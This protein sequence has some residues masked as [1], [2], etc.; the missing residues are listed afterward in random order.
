[1][2]ERI[3]EKLKNVRLRDILHILLFLL[4]VLP[5]A[6]YRRVRPHIWLVCEVNEARDNGY[7][8][9]RYLRLEQPR[10]DAVYAISRRSPDYPMVAD[11]GPTVEYGSF[12]HWIFYLAAELNISSQKN[13]KPDAA[14]CYVLEVLLGLLNNKRVFLQHG[15]I[16]DDLPFLHYE[17]TKLRMF[18]C[19]AKTEYVY[20]RDTFGYPEECVVYTGLCRFDSLLE[21]RVD[22]S[23]ILI[24]PTWRMYLQ[25]S[26]D[27]AEFL[28]SEFY[29]RWNALLNSADF[30]ELLRENGKRAVFCVHREMKSFERFFSSPFENILVLNWEQ[31]DITSLIRSAAVLITDYSSV[32]MDFAYMERPVIYY[33]FD[34]QRFREAHLPKGY[35]DYDRDGFGP[36]CLTEEELLN[37]VKYTISLNC[38]M[39][40]KYRKR[41]EAFYAL[42]DKKN[43]ERTWLCASDLAHRK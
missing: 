27:E 5:A 41:A 23:V 14:V 31:T 18:C 43:C 22:P 38:A 12:R 4:A 30:S 21:A 11:L 28:R 35:F 13:G 16:K 25:R 37:D 34:R 20:V 2:N 8:F 33:Q 26:G 10:I 7:W 9:F 6:V 3:I 19:G 1:M 42:R 36:C 39:D 32:F 17:K 15:V 24:V 29:L 40:D